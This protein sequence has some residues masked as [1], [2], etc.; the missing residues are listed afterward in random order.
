M[1]AIGFT[2]HPNQNDVYDGNIYGITTLNGAPSAFNKNQPY[3]FTMKGSAKDS[4]TLQATAAG[5]DSDTYWGYPASSTAI[6]FDIE[7]GTFAY[8]S[9]DGTLF[10]GDDA[11]EIVPNVIFT[12]AGT[13]TLQTL[14]VSGPTQDS[15]ENPCTRIDIK[16]NGVFSVNA[17]EFNRTFTVDI[18]GT[19]AME[20]KANY[21]SLFSG[22]Y[23]AYGTAPA[24]GYSL[25]LAISPSQPWKTGSITLS[26]VPITCQLFSKAR[27]QS[28]SITFTDGTTLRAEDSAAIEIRCNA[29]TV[30]GSSFNVA[31]SSFPMSH[32]LA[33]FTFIN[34]NGD[35]LQFKISQSSEGMFNFITTK[36][37]NTGL[38]RFRS[39]SAR[40]ATLEYLSMLA[41]RF[42]A[43]DGTICARGEV[44]NGYKLADE[45]YDGTYLIVSLM[46][47]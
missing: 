43:I 25:D 42:F 40:A 17:A 5:E 45:A 41:S 34:V 37:K 7:G 31:G 22:S 20:V 35:Q 28:N 30:A 2:W 47:A 23:R 8:K 33:T 14:G 9:P 4:L 27:L 39:V 13:C 11:S 21:I 3:G 46:K 15:T 32:E 10:L 12:V 44:I 1:S 16:E 24:G 29:I 6:K 38:F 18:A 19:G 36:G 26:K